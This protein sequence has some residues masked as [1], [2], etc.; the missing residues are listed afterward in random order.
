MKTTIELPDELLREAKT[1]AVRRG[2]T[3]KA[4]LTHA[5][6]REVH[7]GDRTATTGFI[8][9]KDG[10]PHLPSRGVKVT[11]ELVSRLLDEEDA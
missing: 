8:V 7:C 5:L 3:L 4:M 1:V 10:L 11:S 6:E 9:D 2:T